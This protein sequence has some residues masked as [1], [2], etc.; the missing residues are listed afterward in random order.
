MTCSW[1]VARNV[2]RPS[3][4]LTLTGHVVA[5]HHYV[6]GGLWASYVW[7]ANDCVVCHQ[8]SHTTC[9]SSHTR[10]HEQQ[11]S[12]DTRIC[13]MYTEHIWHAIEHVTAC[14]CPYVTTICTHAEMGE[15][16]VWASS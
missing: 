11:R 7:Q 8:A 15:R 13:P 2:G 6:G 4:V 5:T 14:A 10:V 1:D 3:N 12:A 16:H 9:M